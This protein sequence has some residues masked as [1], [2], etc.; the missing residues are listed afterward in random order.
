MIPINVD[1]KVNN[2]YSTLKFIIK[3]LDK[4]DRVTKYPCT[5]RVPTASAGAGSSVSRG[6]VI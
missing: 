4:S 1:L 2:K 6:V 3:G 5:V